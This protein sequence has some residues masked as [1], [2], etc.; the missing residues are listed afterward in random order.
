MRRLWALFVGAGGTVVLSY[1]IHLPWKLVEAAIFE[2]IIH[3]I[4]A[5]VG[6]MSPTFQHA[7]NLSI[8]W[9]PPSAHQYCKAA[10]YKLHWDKTPQLQIY[11]FP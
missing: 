5:W 2:T 7:L 6:P 4:S 1:I 11:P 3:E 9:I 10:F 8:S